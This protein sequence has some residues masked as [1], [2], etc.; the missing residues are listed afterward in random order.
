MSNKKRVLILSDWYVPGFKAG[1]PITSVHRMVQ[2]LNG[3]FEFSILTRNTDWHDP[4]PY[5]VPIDVWVKADGALV[6]YLSHPSAS[7]VWQEVEASEYD[8]LYLNGIYSPVF[9]AFPLLR[10]LL[11]KSRKQVIVAPRGMLNANAI[12]LKPLKKRTLLWLYRILGIENKVIFHS[13]GEKES[14]AIRSVYSNARIEEAANLPPVPDAYPEQ[15]RN[16]MLSVARISPVKNTL[17]LLRALDGE[18]HIGLK[19]VGTADDSNYLEQCIDI[20]D[21]N[22][23]MEWLEGK[24]PGEIE[25]LYRSAKFFISMTTGENFGHAIIEALSNGCPVIISDQTPWNDVLECGAG[26]VI[27]LVDEEAWKRVIAEASSMENEAYLAMSRKAVDYVKRKFD[28]EQLREQYTN[29][30]GATY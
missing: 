4:H 21:R 13:T 17:A 28:V 18:A 20:V 26:W 2:Q 25:T 16:G 1:G 15:E 3:S 14:A 19:L 6:K 9:N 30:F 27:P 11:F 5:D 10:C 29:L 8:V 23:G 22:E 7:R 12:A 24:G